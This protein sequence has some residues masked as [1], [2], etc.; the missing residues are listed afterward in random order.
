M[1]VVNIMSGSYA[2]LHL[3]ERPSIPTNRTFRD[4]PGF[5]LEGIGILHDVWLLHY[6][7][8]VTLDFHV[9]DVHDFDILI[10]HPVK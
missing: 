5:I 8:E 4:A 2:F 7:A 10:G 3:G 1:V 9:F 6:N